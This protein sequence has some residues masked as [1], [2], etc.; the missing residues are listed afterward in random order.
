VETNRRTHLAALSVASAEA[1]RLISKER[2]RAVHP[3]AGIPDE[4]LDVEQASQ[5]P[6]RASAARGSDHVGHHLRQSGD[7]RASRN[8]VTGVLGRERVE[9]PRR[10]RWLRWYNEGRPHQ[11]LGYQSPQQFRARQRQLVA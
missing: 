3:V 10:S 8:E 2:E 9:C 6:D 11:A 4:P 1:A 7:R 5:Q